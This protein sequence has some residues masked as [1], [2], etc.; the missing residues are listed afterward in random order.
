MAC[1]PQDVFLDQTLIENFRCEICGKIAITPII[2]PCDHTFGQECYEKINATSGIC[3]ISKKNYK[4]EWKPTTFVTFYNLVSKQTIRCP[5]G[6]K[7]DWNGKVSLW[8]LHDQ[9]DCQA[10]MIKCPHAL[11]DFYS[12][13]YNINRHTSE[14]QFRMIKCEFC[15]K[16]IEFVNLEKHMANCPEGQISCPMN[17]GSIIKR[18]ESAFH[19]ENYCVKMECKCPFNTVGCSVSSFRNE[20]ENHLT[21]EA[22]R[23][24]H[25]LLITQSMMQ[26]RMKVKKSLDGFEEKISAIEVMAH[27]AGENK[28]MQGF[29]GNQLKALV[30]QKNQV[31]LKQT[32]AQHTNFGVLKTNMQS[33]DQRQ[34]S[35]MIEANNAWTKKEFDNGLGAYKNPLI[36]NENPSVLNNSSSREVSQFKNH[37]FTSKLNDKTLLPAQD[38]LLNLDVSFAR[39]PNINESTPTMDQLNQP[40]Y[41][42]SSAKLSNIVIDSRVTATSKNEAGVILLEKPIVPGREYR[43]KIL[44]FKSVTLGFGICSKSFAISKSFRINALENRGYYIM[45]QNGIVLSRDMGLE[46]SDDYDS[47]FEINDVI[48][49]SVNSQLSQLTLKRE[50]KDKSRSIPIKIHKQ[51]LQDFYVCAFLGRSSDSVQ[52]IA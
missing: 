19:L 48:S 4:N 43:F 1:L 40:V 30:T 17:C 31:S 47:L 25:L 24:Q 23:S 49:I 26:W 10:K 36:F 8:P 6:N 22:A 52:I 29:L 3:P 15:F 44:K 34:S 35:S 28:Q 33:L 38:S 39:Q 13:R 11:C 7:C 32:D 5:N 12:T 42:D 50:N 46:S 21:T 37:S 27:D 41:W 20:V 51:E 18:S 9:S 45:C 14:C 2:D 16:A